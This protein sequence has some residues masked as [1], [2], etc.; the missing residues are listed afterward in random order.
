VKPSFSLARRARSDLDSIWS[1]SASRWGVGQ[2][3][4]YIQQ[5]V[6]LC[7]DLGSGRAKGL[8]VRG[9]KAEYL[10]CLVGSHMIFYRARKPSGVAIVRV[11]H[12]SMDVGRHI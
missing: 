5:I 4:A 2:A 3:D 7:S 12:Q 8:P 11:L 10:K 1:Y 6:S 9:A